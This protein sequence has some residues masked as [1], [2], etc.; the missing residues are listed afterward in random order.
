MPIYRALKDVPEQSGH[1]TKDTRSGSESRF[2]I[3][4]DTIRGWSGEE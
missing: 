2:I 4:L 3:L 1:V